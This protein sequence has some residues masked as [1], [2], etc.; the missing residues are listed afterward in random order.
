MIGF[1]LVRGRMRQVKKRKVLRQRPDIPDSG[2]RDNATES[3][4]HDEDGPALD[5]T[6]HF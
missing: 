6:Q 4:F 5:E 3:G 1:L 2:L